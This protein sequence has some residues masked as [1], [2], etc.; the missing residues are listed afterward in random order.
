MVQLCNKNIDFIGNK[1][2]FI[3]RLN[4]IY[5]IEF[6]YNFQLMIWHA[7]E[8]SIEHS[9]EDLLVSAANNSPFIAPNIKLAANNSATITVQPLRTYELNS[10]YTSYAQYRHLLAEKYV[11][12]DQLKTYSPY[13]LN[14]LRF[15]MIKD[16]SLESAFSK[17]LLRKLRLNG[18]EYYSSTKKM[19]KVYKYDKYT[20]VFICE[21]PSI[22]EAAIDMEVSTSAIS[23]CCMGRTKTVKDF[24]W[25]YIKT[26]KMPYFTD[27]RKKFRLHAEER[28]ALLNPKNR[29]AIIEEKAKKF[30][31]DHN[32]L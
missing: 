19:R 28:Y 27:D 3:G 1:N 22:T 30:M 16:E 11:L 15:T 21:Y 18:V 32:T 10:M 25:S 2:L 23:N 7:H 17:K 8:D 14:D 12:I 6:D 24:I 4:S 26:D 20:G 13:G 9:L 29:A 31:E 5:Q